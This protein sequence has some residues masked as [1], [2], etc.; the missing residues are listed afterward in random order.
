MAIAHVEGE[1]GTGQVVG[2]D[3]YQNRQQQTDDGGFRL[4][5]R[6]VHPIFG[7][8]IIL[9]VEGSGPRTR[10][11]INFDREGLKWLMLSHA[12]LTAA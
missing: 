2:H 10:V 6:V 5:Q 9:N 3:Q 7:D 11:Q 8:G 1:G 4:G 12:N